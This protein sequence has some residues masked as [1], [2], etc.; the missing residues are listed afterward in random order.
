MAED[1]KED[2]LDR[3]RPP[4]WP[5]ERSLVTNVLIYKSTADRIAALPSFPPST[6]VAPDTD[7]A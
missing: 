1:G 2:G 7:P 3:G 4:D 5:P 6:Y